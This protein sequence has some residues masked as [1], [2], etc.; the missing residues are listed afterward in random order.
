MGRESPED[1]Q[2][3]PERPTPDLSGGSPI[4]GSP[5]APEAPVVPTDPDEV[6]PK[7]LLEVIARLRNKQPRQGPR[8]QV[9]AEFKDTQVQI[10]QAAEMLLT[11]EADDQ[12]LESAVG[13]KVDSMS[14]LVSLDEKGVREQQFEFA[15]AL[16]KDKRPVLAKLGERIHFRTLIEAFSAG[17]VENPESLVDSFHALTTV[18]EADP[19]VLGFA[20]EVA[21]RMIGRGFMKEGAELLRFAAKLFEGNEDAEVAAAANTLYEQAGLVESGLNETI[22]AALDGKPGAAGE[23]AK[24][25]G[26]LVNSEYAAQFTF[27]NMA[28]LAAG[29]ESEDHEMAVAVYEAMESGFSDHAD[30]TIVA[31][32][33]EIVEKFRERNAIVGTQFTFEGVLADGTPFDAE[34]YKGKV[35]LVDFWATWCR[36]CLEEIPNIKQNFD[37][38]NKHGFE[39]VGVNIDK[40]RA[41]YTEFAKL[42][43]LPWP[44]VLSPDPDQPHPMA[45]TY[46]VTAIPFLVLLD[47]E[48]KVLGVNTRGTRL[49]RELAKLFPDVPVPDAE[50]PETP[51]EA[52]APDA[53]KSET[54]DKPVEESTDNKPAAQDGEDKPAD[55][56]AEAPASDTSQFADSRTFFVALQEEKG[57]SETDNT[58]DSS[59]VNPY[60][61]PKRL[62][63]AELA[64]FIFD[65]R[66]KPK[67]IQRR[68]GFAEAIVDAA[69][70]ILAANMKDKYDAIAVVAKL[71]ALHKEALDGDEADQELMKF[72][73]TLGDDS[74]TKVARLRTFYELETRVLDTEKLSQD[75]LRELLAEVSSFTKDTKL[76]QRH[77]R[78]ASS[79]VGAI[80]RLETAEE[81]E[82]YFKQFG[83]VFSKSRD[84]ELASYGRRVA[85]TKARKVVDLVGK[86]LELEG[87]TALGTGFDW[88]SYRGR[89]VLV[90]FWATWCG[91]CRRQMPAIKTLLEEHQDEG[92]EVVAVSLDRN[93]ETLSTYLE[94]E[95]IFWT[96][97]VGEDAI[98]LAKKHGIVAVPTMFVV[99]GEGKVMAVGHGVD[100]LRGE[101]ERLLAQK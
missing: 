93:L 46:A 40:D 52:A 90:D 2:T 85:G 49:R 56:A 33:K 66:E 29:L 61:A 26:M 81:R 91:P 17:E 39:V 30:Q 69:E 75:E 79:T 50:V 68:D 92:L 98:G 14:L 65:M 89:I 47:G 72:V 31:Q 83:G 9:I 12:T 20:T 16:S 100:E 3:P 10:I 99:D 24:A 77:L 6:T 35:V 80:N 23:F 25:V 94:E 70:R 27:A 55:P 37:L 18:K 53:A 101:V 4:A 48:G 64:D 28:Q 7:Q 38:Y 34:K 97:L 59:D 87:T 22:I 19:E 74:R 42:Q 63:R 67:S 62:S 15:E 44:S 1:P 73:R 5:A 88:S 36:P 95:K 51:D 96:N 86:P 58:L 21:G 82:K 43:P 41:A 13:A 45:E 8:E 57:E 76:D 54:D 71:E 84:K 60:A 32:S 11:M 78:L